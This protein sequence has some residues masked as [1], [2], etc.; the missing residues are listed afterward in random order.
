MVGSKVRSGQTIS[1]IKFSVLA[2]VERK[3]KPD[4][5][6]TRLLK[7]FHVAWPEEAIAGPGSIASPSDQSSVTS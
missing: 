2:E 1:G 6:S 4:G 5:Y 7:A 3:H